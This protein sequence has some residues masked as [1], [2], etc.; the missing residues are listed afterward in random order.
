VYNTARADLERLTEL[1]YLVR[2]KLGRKFVF[3]AGPRLRK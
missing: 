3:R 1:G 2:K